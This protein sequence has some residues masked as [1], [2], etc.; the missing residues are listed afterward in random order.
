MN[1]NKAP[2]FASMEEAARA[3][4]IEIKREP[5]SGAWTVADA[6][7]GDRPSRGAGRVYVFPDGQGG[8]AWNWRP[9]A[10]GRALWFIDAGRSMSEEE[11]QKRRHEAALVMKAAEEKRRKRARKAARFAEDLLES[12][13]RAEAVGHEYLRRKHVRPISALGVMDAA[14]IQA[15]FN[16]FYQEEP[17]TLWDCKAG[18][19]MSGPVL[20]VP[21]YAGRRFSKVCSMEFISEAG[22]KYTLPEA[23]AA[24][25]LWLPES[26]RWN[27]RG[28]EL[29]GIAEGLATAL[30]VSQVK[31]FPVVAARSCGNLKAA[32]Q[33]VALHYPCAR[34]IVLGDKGNGEKQAREAAKC[35]HALVA[36]PEFPD[37]L[38]ANFKRITG[39]ASAPTDFNDFYLA[40][41]E[42]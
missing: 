16:E 32:S 9:C 33:A 8:I 28:P 37:E 5:R 7:D 15:R 2:V 6:V 21:L 31:G 36:V 23:R 34:L 14:A 42:L 25:A 12:A 40:T 20:M 11:L 27:L 35:A 24:G 38:V 17:R 1:M 19:A 30:S 10:V 39:S 22:G 26:L 4:Q 41:E 3:V 13:E 18:R 29:I